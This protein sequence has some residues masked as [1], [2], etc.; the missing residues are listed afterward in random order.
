MTARLC[1]SVPLF[2]ISEFFMHKLFSGF[3]VILRCFYLFID[4]SICICIYTYTHIYIYIYISMPFFFA[5]GLIFVIFHFL[6]NSEVYLIFP[7][8]FLF[9]LFRLRFCA[10]KLFLIRPSHIFEFLP[11]IS[12]L[13]SKR[14]IRRIFYCFYLLFRHFSRRCA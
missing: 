6:L 9:D 14:K 5:F 13:N 4:I 12:F 3:I 1:S 11:C 10:L 8:R 2:Y 7:C